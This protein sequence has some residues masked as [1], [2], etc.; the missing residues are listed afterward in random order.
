M[1]AAQAAGDNRELGKF[2]WAPQIGPQA[3]ALIATWADELFFGGARGGGKS[4]YLLGDYLQD[5]YRYGDAWQGIIFRRTMP[6]LEEL[7]YR[8]QEIYPAAGGQ[9]YEGK[10][11]WVFPGGARLRMRYLERAQDAGRY[12]GHQ[13]TWIGFDE[14]TQWPDDVP[15]RMLLA[16]LRSGRREVPT[17]R[18]RSS[19]NPGGV[20]HN[21][22]KMRF[23]D[24]A[25]A[26]HEVHEDEDTGMLRLFIPSRV[27][28]NK[29]LLDRDPQYVS[30]LKGVGS[31]ELV[32]AWLEGDWSAVTGAYFPE[33]SMK[34]HVKKPHAIPEHWP[35]F[36]SLDWGSARP[37]CV[38]WYAVADGGTEVKIGGRNFLYPKGAVIKYREWYGSSG[39]NVGLK[40][41]VEEV[42]E[43]IKKREKGER[44]HVYSVADPAI[45]ATDGGPSM[46]ERFAKRGVVFR[47]ADN[48][49]VPGWKTCAPT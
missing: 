39:P 16:C 22:V 23:I 43:G 17:K 4:D 1:E 34:F 30:R 6:E 35:T 41:T 2:A 19:G 3:E 12:Q 5:V 29:I 44:K 10:K 46:A 26:G 14:L 18:I 33:F 47:R 45:F 13:Y 32:R 21:W 42:A 11:I 31:P 36:R 27:E 25:P 48:K 24:H 49:R 9:W 37:F 7:I 38:G 28:D 40:M 8:S 15:Y 20:G